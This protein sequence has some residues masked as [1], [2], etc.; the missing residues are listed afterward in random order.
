MRDVRLLVALTLA[1][2]AAVGVGESA[3]SAPESVQSPL[4]RLFERPDGHGDRLALVHPRTLRPVS[5]GVRT[6]LDGFGGTFSPDRRLFAYGN[7]FDGR[8]LVQLIDVQRWSTQARIDLRGDGPVA[9]AWPTRDR[10]IAVTGEFFGR[11]RLLVLAAPDGQVLAR[12]SFRGRRLADAATPLGLVMLVAPDRGI[13]PA[14]ILYVSVDGGMRTIEVARIRAGG[15][16][17]RR[18]GGRF[19]LPGLTV[20]PVAG[21][22]Y[23]VAAGPMLGARID[24]A[25]GAIEYHELK[26]VGPARRAVAAKGSVAAWWRQASWLG[27]GRIAVTGHYEPPLRPGRRLRP[28]NRPFGVRLIDTG[29]WTIRTLHPDA[30]LMHRAGNRLLANG[31]TW[32][33]GWT[34]STSTGLLAFDMRGQRAFTRFRGADVSVLGSHGRLAYVWVRPTRMLHVLDLRSGD[35]LRR[36]RVGPARVP[37]LFSATE[38]PP[39]S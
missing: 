4:V 1:V 32:H 36:Q 6:F 9:L 28:A 30:F 24:L 7:G 3:R 26:A 35:S 25:S 15:N 38:R 13:G 22:A 19:R 37:F 8:A 2:A 11:Q 31:T 27:D 29:D 17:G 12:R 34:R 18:R 20:D 23:L 21:A 39:G 5:P 33:A 16:E 10:L 14:R